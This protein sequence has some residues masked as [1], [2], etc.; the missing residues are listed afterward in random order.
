MQLECGRLAENPLSPNDLLDII[1]QATQFGLKGAPVVW[2]YEQCKVQPVW[3]NNKY[4]TFQVDLPLIKDTLTQFTLQTFPT[5]VN[6]DWMQLKCIVILG[7]TQKREPCQC[8]KHVGALTQYYARQD[9]TYRG[10]LPCERSVILQDG[11]DFPTWHVMTVTVDG[12][13]AEMIQPGLYVT[14]T[15]DS[16]VEVRCFEQATYRNAIRPGTNQISFPTI[17]CQVEG[18]SGWVLHN[19]ILH[20][21]HLT[22]RAP[23]LNLSHIDMPDLPPFKSLPDFRITQLKEVTGV[24]IEELVQ[25]S[26]PILPQPHKWSN[27]I[28]IV[29]LIIC[30]GCGVAIYFVRKKRLLCLRV[31]TTPAKGQDVT[32][33]GG[34]QPC[35][36][37]PEEPADGLAAYST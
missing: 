17:P 14:T 7:T 22:H 26:N 21:S 12:T 15:A 9:L 1:N 29:M 10:G 18:D 20:T 16:S 11:H 33:D 23:I 5:L 4:L 24:S 27:T 19:T 8:F 6:K 13:H 28:T 34:S 31:S 35:V 2:Y 37:P 36:A 32:K 25:L 3:E 30:A